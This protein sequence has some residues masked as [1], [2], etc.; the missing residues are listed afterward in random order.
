MKTKWQGPKGKVFIFLMI[1]CLLIPL[2][3]GIHHVVNAQS[4]A[5]SSD[6]ASTDTAVDTPRYLGNY[7]VTADEDGNVYIDGMLVNDGDVIDDRVRITIRDVDEAED[8]EGADEPFSLNI[9]SVDTETVVTFL[10]TDEGLEA[11]RQILYGTGDMTRDGDTPVLPDD[12]RVELT[13]QIAPGKK[14][15]PEVPLKFGL[16]V[17]NGMY[18]DLLV[19]D[20]EL[21]EFSDM[22][23]V[24]DVIPESE[25]SVALT[26]L[27]P[28][29]LS[30]RLKGS[31]GSSQ[32]FK[33]VSWME[34]APDAKVEVTELMVVDLPERFMVQERDDEARQGC[35]SGK[36][37]EADR[38]FSNKIFGV[39]FSADSESYPNCRGE[40]T[41]IKAGVTSKN[42]FKIFGIRFP[43]FSETKSLSSYSY[44]H[45]E[46]GYQTSGGSSYCS[47]NCN[48]GECEPGC[49]CDPDCSDKDSCAC[50]IGKNSCDVGCDCDKDCSK[51]IKEG[52]EAEIK[53]L[54]KK[55]FSLSYLKTGSASTG[56][57]KSFTEQ[58]KVKYM[59]VIFIIPVE[60]EAGAYGELGLQFQFGVEHYAKFYAKAGP[61]IDVGAFASAKV[62]VIVAWAGI[63]GTLSLIRDEFW[64]EVSGGMEV[65]S[66]ARDLIMSMGLRVWNDLYGPS[67]RLAVFAGYYYPG[68]CKKEVCGADWLA[69]ILHTISFGLF[70]DDEICIDLP[71]PCIKTKEKD[72]TLA[73]FH[74]FHE[75][76]V[77]LD[78][79]ESKTIRLSAPVPEVPELPF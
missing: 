25:K 9:Q 59:V 79:S 52:F 23:R 63:R 39:E 22:L 56:F 2:T 24:Y 69:D 17:R 55:L 60:L 33:I 75:E 68:I 29:E 73:D 3:D 61:F 44:I 16:E 77:L 71:Y 1:F 14:E 5:D 30:E 26:L 70:D 43:D 15:Q 40:Y 20:S 54:G 62:T 53:S 11:Q 50:D 64:G 7:E 27:I 31:I 66:G 58:I 48:P 4:D 67:G 6:P 21:Q 72:W 13:V 46:Y 28:P 34:N 18:A 47:C 78:W 74:T 36:S 35:G 10:P 45:D 32:T 49:Q 8:S 76:S 41:E 37:K 38:I 57:K 12:G 19:W 65:R 42:G 51:T